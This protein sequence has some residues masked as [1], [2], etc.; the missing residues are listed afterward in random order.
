MSRYSTAATTESRTPAT[1]N[2][3]VL[4]STNWPTNWRPQPGPAR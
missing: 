2:L 4:H 1:W 3:Y